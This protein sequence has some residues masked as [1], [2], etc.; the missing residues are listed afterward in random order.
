MVAHSQA[1]ETLAGLFTS[2]YAST[3]LCNHTVVN[4]PTG[5][6]NSLTP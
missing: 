6:G 1:C 4:L 3:A 2:R 5:L